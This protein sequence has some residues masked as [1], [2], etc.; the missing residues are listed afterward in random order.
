[1]DKLKEEIIKK[2][3]ELDEATKEHKAPRFQKYF[4]QPD[5]IT[6]WSATGEKVKDLEKQLGDLQ[7][8]RS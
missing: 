2:Q 3:M 1:M 7:S 8:R 6:P 5:D 4:Y